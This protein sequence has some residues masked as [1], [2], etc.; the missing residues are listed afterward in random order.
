MTISFVTFKE[1]KQFGTKVEQ[2]AINES[3]Q[4]NGKTVF[5]SHSSMDHELVPG[6]LLIL[7]NH[8]AKVYVDEKDAEMPK[9]DYSAVAERLRSAVKGCRRF[10]LL[11]TTN[12]KQSKW[13]PWELG[14]GDGKALPSNVALFPSSENSFDQSWSETEYLG[15]Y[16]RI[17]WGNFANQKEEWLVYNHKDNSAVKLSN[18][19]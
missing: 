13:I 7:E 2:R 11:V 12:S 17:I 1:L 5:L 8:G 14:L 16:Q 18:W 19:L 6:V 10:V 15:I 9:G 3:K 4:I